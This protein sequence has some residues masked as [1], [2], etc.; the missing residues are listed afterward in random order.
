MKLIFDGPYRGHMITVHQ[1]QTDLFDY[2]VTRDDEHVL[3]MPGNYRSLSIAVQNAVNAIDQYIDLPSEA[4]RLQQM[5]AEREQAIT[6]PQ[7]E[8]NGTAD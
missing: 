3:S 8:P 2:K 6:Q 7:E 5:L 4:A 1:W